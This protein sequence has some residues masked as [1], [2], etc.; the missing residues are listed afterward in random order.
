MRL[1]FIFTSNQQELDSGAATQDSNLMLHRIRMRNF[2][3]HLDTEIALQ[4][5]TM[6]TGENASG[7]TS[8]LEAIWLQAIIGATPRLGQSS[9]Y[10]LDDLLRRGAASIEIVTDTSIAAARRR[11]V[12]LHRGGANTGD[13]WLYEVHQDGLDGPRSIKDAVDGRRKLSEVLW[14]PMPTFPETVS[15]YRFRSEKVAAS[16]YSDH[17]SD[18]EVRG[19]GSDTAVVLANLKTAQDECFARIESALI[20]LVPSIRKIRIHP[21]PTQ[22]HRTSNGLVSGH[23]LSFDLHDADNVPAHAMGEGALHLLPLLTVLYT[24][25]QPGVLL[26][27]DL[28]HG[29]DSD[30]QR[31]LAK[32]L[33]SLLALDEFADLQV[34]ATTRSPFVAFEL[35]RT[36]V[37]NFSTSKKSQLNA[38][39]IMNSVTSVSTTTLT[40]DPEVS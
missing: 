13:D 12:T 33:Q 23:A 22:R 32:M 34:I 14:P 8:V 3:P 19:D 38:A 5:L 31:A 2:K 4:R 37:C 29:L 20:A 11:Q 27:D 10:C 39:P 25:R 17:P 1:H 26:V 40:P 7:K 9:P 30:A 21:A 36:S 6:L 16:A 18:A 15:L 24:R 35:P 28:D